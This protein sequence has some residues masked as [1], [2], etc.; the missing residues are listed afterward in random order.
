[1]KYPRQPLRALLAGLIAFG[2][3][4]TQAAQPS[5]G[6]AESEG[7]A[8]AE[9]PASGLAALGLNLTR[10]PIVTAGTVSYDL[11]ASQATG[12]SRTVAHLVTGTLL[13]NTYIYQPWFATATGTLGFTAGLATESAN[14]DGSAGPF[15]EAPRAATR[16][17][18]VTGLARVKVFPQ[19]RFP[20]EFHVERSDSRVDTAAPT[21]L[22][23]RTQ[24]IG[25]S[26]RYRPASNGYTL[27]ASFDRRD[28]WA[29]G[30]RDT[31]HAL[32][33]DF[34][35]YWKYHDLTLGAAWNETRRRMSDER[36]EFRSLLARHNYAPSA[37]GS[38]NTTVNWSQSLEN[39]I[40]V[41]SDLTVLQ[42]STVGLLRRDNS[43][44]LLTGAVR[45]L[46]LRDG[47]GDRDLDSLGLTLGA[48]YELSHN[49]RLSASGSANSTRSNGGAATGLT[50]AFAANWQGDTIEFKGLRYDW[51]A[52]TTAAVSMN[53]DGAARE[54]ADAGNA[55]QSTAGL[56]VGHGV[57]RTFQ[58]T[59]Q[60]GLLLNA[61][62][63]FSIQAGDGQAGP[64]G[65]DRSVQHNASAAWNVAADGRT[66]YA[67]LSYNDFTDL[68]GG[69]ARFQLWNFQL[70]GNFAIN[71]Y[72]TVGGDFTWQRTDQRIGVDAALPA[73][74]QRVL[75]R[76]ASGELAYRH[77]RLFG[78]Q[79]LRFSS[80]IKLAQD[81]LHQ[82]GML[83]AIPDRE[84]RAWENR[85]DWSIGRLESQLI[86][87]LSEVDG[88]RRDFLMW[89]IQRSFGN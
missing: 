70:S 60:S 15:A 85:L 30:V 82:P 73:G 27:A 52:S 24:N 44:L 26:Q 36:S 43:P 54:P 53:D 4:T 86:V 67:R 51:F 75:S 17:R 28:Q 40:T 20:F 49:A 21:S 2:G 88:R 46:A 39:R 50:G 59:S 64:K 79:R 89:R 35:T 81:V 71:R 69:P 48:T 22:D 42:W 68:G 1:M 84:T 47:E 14:P 78:F 5:G 31:Q 57:S 10:A 25:F 56:Q 62:Q 3:A 77:Q 55:V 38:L 13:A 29:R 16:D 65:A 23:V 58:L 41:P 19:S 87:R 61:G 11:R 8:A 12:E 66:G 74:A 45:G 9:P 63:T 37:A 80:R 34:G 7:A 76:G 72:Q 33:G 6:R 32:T 18:F 83:S